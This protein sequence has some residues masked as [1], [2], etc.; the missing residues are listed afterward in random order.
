MQSIGSMEQELIVV[1]FFTTIKNKIEIFYN[2]SKKKIEKIILE[3]KTR[4]KNIC[5][6]AILTFFIKI[7]TFL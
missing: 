2:L 3:M 7:E 6:S 4:K 1:K 5:S